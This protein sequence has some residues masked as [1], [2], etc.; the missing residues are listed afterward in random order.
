MRIAIIALVMYI[1]AGFGWSI[2]EIEMVKGLGL[3]FFIVIG[4]MLALLQDIKEI[5]K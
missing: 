4:M 2:D 5:R 3:I 1:S